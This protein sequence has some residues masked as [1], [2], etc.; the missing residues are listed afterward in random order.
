MWRQ[1]VDTHIE[2]VKEFI[3]GFLVLQEQF[4][5][6]KN[7]RRY[8]DRLYQ[9]SCNLTGINK[10]YSSTSLLLVY[11]NPTCGLFFNH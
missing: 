1:L 6:L 3:S 8:K 7:L 2:A 11:L 5:I 4:Q 9:A 10:I